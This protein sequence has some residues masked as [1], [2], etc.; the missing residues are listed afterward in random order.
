MN[1]KERKS[2]RRNFFGGMAGTVAAASVTGR[3]GANAQEMKQYKITIPKWDHTGP[4]IIDMHTHFSG[5]MDKN[6][7]LK[8][9]GFCDKTVVFGGDDNDAVKSLCDQAPDRLVFFTRIY[10]NKENFMEELERTHQDLG[11]KGIKIG[12]GYDDVHPLDHRCRELYSYAQKHNLPIVTH[13]AETPRNSGPLEYQRPIHADQIACDYP[14][15]KLCLA[16]MGHPWIDETIC[17][18]RRNNFIYADI[19]ALYYRPWQFYNAIK[20]AIEYSDMTTVQ[21]LFF[22]TDYMGGLTSKFVPRT[23]IEGIRNMN[24]IAGKQGPEPI[25]DEIIENILHNDALKILGIE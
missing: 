10:F 2:T 16:H 25:P 7:W 4:R 3:P 23:S 20:T 1:T 14:D 9:T 22:G 13:M 24:Y 6:E 11:A 12:P 8:A 18:V 5:R 21:K 17:V 19:S 15:L